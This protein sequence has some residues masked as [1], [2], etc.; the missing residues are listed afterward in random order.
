IQDQISVWG[1][2]PSPSVE[3]LNQDISFTDQGRLIFYASRPT[4]DNAETFNQ[5]CP[6]REENS[7]I[8]GCFDGRTISIYNV[9]E[10]DLAGIQQV[11]A[12]H[13]MLHA[14]WTRL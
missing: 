4:V 5:N 14:V 9:T 1:F 11:T 10:S 7:P 12:A 13:E 3:A 2:T 6:Q 8:L